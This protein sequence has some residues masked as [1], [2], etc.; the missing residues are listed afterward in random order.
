MTWLKKPP[1]PSKLVSLN[2]IINVKIID[3]D[4]E[5]KRISLPQTDKIKSMGQIE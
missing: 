5:K 3:I 1:H 4:N 2:D